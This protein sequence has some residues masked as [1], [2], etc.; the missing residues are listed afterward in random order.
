MSPEPK[1]GQSYRLSQRTVA[2]DPTGQYHRS[3]FVRENETVTVTN[4]KFI[5]QIYKD[6]IE[7]DWHGRMVLIS[8]LDLRSRGLI[9]SDGAR[10]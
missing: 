1:V 6:Y 10:S 4:N 8:S 5:S 9:V 2:I 3:F 7:V